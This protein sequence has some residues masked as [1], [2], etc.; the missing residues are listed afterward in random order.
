LLADI[1]LSPAGIAQAC[2]ALAAESPV[3]L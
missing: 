3:Q 2:R 1:Q